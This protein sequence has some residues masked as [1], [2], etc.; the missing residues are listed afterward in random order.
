[1][2]SNMQIIMSDTFYGLMVSAVVL[3]SLVWGP[4]IAFMVRKENDIIGYRQIYFETQTPECELRLLACVHGPRPVATMVGLVGASRGPENI[5]MT[6]YLMHL[7]ELPGKSNTDLMYNQKEEDELSDDDDYGGNE[8]VEI[9]DAVDIFTAET[10]V[11]VHQIKA[12]APLS[13]MYKDVCDYAEDIRASI[14]LLPF[15]KHQRIDGKLETSKE[16]IRTTNQKVLRYAPCA[17][18][19]LVDRGLTAGS[20][21]ITG[22]DSLQHIATLFFGGPDDREALGFSK[23]LGMHNRINLTVI[24]FLSASAKGQNVGVDIAHKEENVLMAISDRETETEADNEVLSEF[25]HRYTKIH[26]AY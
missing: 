13:S 23:R 2:Y 17:V 15:H 20:L 14:I 10:G 22:S 26:L 12:V 18:A 11:M 16:G 19:I 9:N 8:V 6:P 21:N 24:R 7:V 25:Y 5:P 3:N 1:M 4:I